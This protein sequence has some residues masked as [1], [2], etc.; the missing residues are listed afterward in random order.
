MLRKLPR[1]AALAP[2]LFTLP[3]ILFLGVFFLLPIGAMLARAVVSDEVTRG[4]PATAERLAQAGETPALSEGLAAALV[5]D[6]T[7]D[8]LR[9]ERAEAARRLN[10]EI[11]GF[12]TLLLGTARALRR[13]QL[14]PER[15]EPAALRARLLEADPRWGDADYWAALRRASSLFTDY[16]LLN[17]FDLRR[18]RD[19]EIVAVP[20]ERR[21]FVDVLVRTITVSL[22][23]TAI[24]LAV[25][26]PF[27]NFLTR[28]GGWV[29]IVAFF[30]VLLPF[31]TS[32]LVRTSAWIVV[33]QREGLVNATLRGLLL[34]DEPLALIFN[35]TGV[36]VVM[37]HVLLPFMVLPLFSTMSAI[38][39][40]YAKAARSLGATPLKSFLYVYLP[41][42]LPGV[43]SGSL[44]TFI[45]CIGYY[46][47]PALVGGPKDQMIGYFIA[48]FTNQELNWGMAAALALIL[49][50]LIGGAYV[51]LSRTV[52]LTAI[53][54]GQK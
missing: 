41:L 4:L 20:P 30:A 18:D 42:S 2:Y 8:D 1:S 48:F 24:V 40:I 39:P 49:L 22:A 19:D 37:V 35:R 15:E 31:W 17:A 32:L 50:S 47:T 29:R 28:V 36:Y 43:I 11:T 12:R 3:M 34:T 13:L 54:S 7:N 45:V 26:Y 46:V 44:L 9:I 5:R 51:A 6:L 23:V 10:Y 33:L 27:A 38:R 25:A 53:L 16:Y 14:D 21:I 52:G